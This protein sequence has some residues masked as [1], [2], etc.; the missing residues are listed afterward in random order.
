MA[1]ISRRG[2]AAAGAL[3]LGGCRKERVATGLPSPPAGPVSSG[4]S[5]RSSQSATR[6]ALFDPV[7][8]NDAPRRVLYTW[9]TSE[10]VAELRRRPVLLTRASSPTLGVGYLFTLLGE[11][12]ARG[13]ALAR[14]LLDPRLAKGRFAWANPWATCKGVTGEDYGAELLRVVLKPAR[15]QRA[16]LFHA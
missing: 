3:L 6:E 8:D 5:S 12:A 9:T 7:N 14:R 16:R 15:R 4:G 1:R 11:R 13:D 10:Q 2:F